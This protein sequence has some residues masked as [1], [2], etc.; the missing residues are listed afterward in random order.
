MMM[1]PFG[2]MPTKMLFGGR[3][4]PEQWFGVGNINS[5]FGGSF[6]AQMLADSESRETALDD[7][8]LA[9]LAESADID[10]AELL[11]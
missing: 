7:E 9:Q 11:A 2:M 10:R 4:K 5:F 3:M 8:V 1:T 6:F